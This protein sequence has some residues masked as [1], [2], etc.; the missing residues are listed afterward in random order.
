MSGLTSR[1]SFKFNLTILILCIFFLI[2]FSVLAPYYVKRSISSSFGTVMREQAELVSHN[3]GART[4]N[5]YLS[6]DSLPFSLETYTGMYDRVLVADY[7]GIVVYD[8]SEDNSRLSQRFISKEVQAALA[9]D[10]SFISDFS[11]GAFTFNVLVPIYFDGDIGGV[12]YLQK[13]EKELGA[14]YQR[15]TETLG[16]VGM[17][18]CVVPVIVG[19][20]T[21]LCFNGRLQK[22]LSGIKIVQSGDYSH[23]FD[24]KGQDELSE[25]CGE[26]NAL[27]IKYSENEDM[28]RRFVS[29]ASHELKTPLA[30]IK[31]LSDSI[32]QTP[33]M[34]IDS[35]REFLF[36]INNEIDRLT[37]ISSKLL[38]ITRFDDLAGKTALTP[39][40]LNSVI[41]NVCRMLTPLAKSANCAIKCELTPDCVVPANYDLIYQ[42]FYNIIENALK[43]GG[44]NHDVHVYLYKHEGKAVFIADDEG[45][46]IPEEDLKRIFD[47]FYRV[48]KARARATGGT[49]LGL[50]IVASAVQTCG[51]TVEAQNRPNGGARFI[52]TFPLSNDEGSQPE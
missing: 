6:N 52:I 24:L 44:A 33:D 35:I 19:I 31:L 11:D 7:D 8:S 25:L 4:L 40:D 34:D 21:A 26:L 43:Y 22:I 18:C 32:I 9:G 51:G 45:E 16:Y 42:A 29:D 1:I 17:A 36:D 14:K 30:S 13:T 12:L 10:V 39:L 49:G 23:R 38:Q 27:N 5:D 50:S 20:Y 37:R 47:R 28:R 48:D 46:G 3:T 41:E 2:V 15:T